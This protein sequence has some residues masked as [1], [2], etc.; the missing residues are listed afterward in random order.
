MTTDDSIV[1]FYGVWKSVE[2]YDTVH[3][4]FTTI[5]KNIDNIRKSD[6]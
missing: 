1:Y 6:I 2:K 4:L 3:Y 5:K